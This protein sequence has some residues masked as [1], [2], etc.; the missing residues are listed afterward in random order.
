[1]IG[2]IP[3][4]CNPSGLAIA[5]VLRQPLAATTAIL[6][7]RVH[8]IRCG[9]RQWYPISMQEKHDMTTVVNPKS[10]LT[11]HVARSMFDLV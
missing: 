4:S 10:Y 11:R 2:H 8:E 1:M 5:A 7:A 6:L 9:T 3:K